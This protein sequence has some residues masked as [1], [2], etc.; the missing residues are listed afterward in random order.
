M[1]YLV[2]GHTGFK[3]AWLT[4]LLTEQGHTVSGLSLDPAPGAL[5]ERAR[6]QRGPART[7]SGS[8][9]GTPRRRR[10][11]IAADRA[12]RGPAPGRPAAGA[13]VVPRPAG[14]L[15]DQRHGHAARARGGR[16]RR[17]ASQAQ[18]V[19]TTDKVY[20]TST[21]SGATARTSRSAASTRT[22][23]PRRRPTSSPSRWI[24]D[25]GLDG[26][27]RDRARG[28]RHRRW[29]RLPRAAHGRPGRGVLGRRGR[30]AALPGRGPPVAARA[31]LPA[32]LPPAGRRSARRPAGGRGVQ[33]RT[34]HRVVRPRRRHRD[35]G[36]DAVGHG[37]AASSWTRARRCTRRACSRW[38]RARPRSRSAGTTSCACPTR[39]P[40]RSSGPRRSARA[41]TRG[42]RRSRRCASTST[43]AGRRA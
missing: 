29:R 19:V 11:A 8:T 2:T 17:R 33:L 42:A 4:L 40:G 9:S 1:H 5:Y 20:R 39:S 18:V 12:G 28:Q 25:L 38:T 10:D 16:R 37:R 41:P 34:R 3:G 23:R 14:H 36:G 31:R 7:T 32:R 21:R 26:A 13:G 15:R 30:A 24:A 22:R 43:L 27:D 6:L 35:L